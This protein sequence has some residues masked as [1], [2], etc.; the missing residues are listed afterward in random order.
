MTTT[1]QLA[2]VP[3]PESYWATMKDP[4][5]MSLAELL[6]LLRAIDEG[7]VE[8]TKE[9]MTELAAALPGKV[10]DHVLGVQELRGGAA[11]IRELVRPH[12]DKAAELEAE[13][14]NLDAEAFAEIATGAVTKLPG[15]AFRLAVKESCRCVPLRPAPTD[16]DMMTHGSYVRVKLEWDKNALTKGLKGADPAAKSAARFELQRSYE[17]EANTP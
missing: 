12:L 2:S 8:A 17:W 1:A 7:A 5:R 4:A 10:D 13:A 14:E 6:Q 16:D 3:A 15:R 9:R 11:A